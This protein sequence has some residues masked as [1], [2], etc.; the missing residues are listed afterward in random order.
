MIIKAYIGGHAFEVE[1]GFTPEQKGDLETQF[2]EEE[3]IIERVWLGEN[4]INQLLVEE[5]C[6][7]SDQIFAQVMTRIKEGDL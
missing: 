1:C 4:E 2:I 5:C 3:L 6:D 7:L